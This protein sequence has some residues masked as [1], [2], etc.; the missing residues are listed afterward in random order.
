M[1]TT[2]QLESSDGLA[3]AG[4]VTTAR[5][6]FTTPCFMPVGTRGAIKHLSSADMEDL[7]AQ[8]ILSNNYHL[9]LR[10]G[11]DVVEALGGLH[12][13]ADWSGHTLTDSGGYQ[14]FS[15][16]P[17][18]TDEGATFRSVYDGSTHVMTPESAV[19]T[20]VSIGADIQMVLD[21]CSALPSTDQVI[22][23]AMNRTANWAGRARQAFLDHPTAS[24]KQSQFGIVQGGLSLDMRRESAE[25]TLEIGFDGYAVGGLS[26]G[27]HRSEWHEPLLAVTNNLPADQPRYFMGL[28]DPAGIVDAVGRGIDMF[29]C[30]L[31]TRLARHGTLLTSAGRTNLTRAEYAT[32]DE[33]ID[34]E[35][36]ASR[37]SKGYLR[38]LLQVREPTAQRI[39]TLHNLWW[40]LRFV[41]DMRTA[42]E[43]ERFESFAAEVYELWA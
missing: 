2:F 17:K 14:V 33:P 8:V 7:G 37:W 19:G 3:R 36:P 1:H 26:V 10:P 30:V 31:P 42:I 9:M 13:M 32:S 5:G 43:Q 20:Q 18:I 24:E 35:G 15:L 23:E 29:D 39:L 4:T 22:R 12:K 27:E 28:G 21:V 34:P 40:L 25:R 38:H 11:A 6:T 16:E 41:D